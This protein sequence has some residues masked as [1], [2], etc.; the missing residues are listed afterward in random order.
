MDKARTRGVI[1]PEMKKIKDLVNIS[2]Q[3]I[4]DLNEKILFM[5]DV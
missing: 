5:K 3:I 1:K 4:F 2:F